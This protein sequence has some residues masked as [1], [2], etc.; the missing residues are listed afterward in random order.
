[1]DEY[2]KKIFDFMKSEEPSQRLQ[3]SI[4]K[5]LKNESLIN[6]TQIM[7]RERIFWMAATVAGI[8][9]GL[10]LNARFQ[11]NTTQPQA[12]MK[13]LQ[14]IMLLHEDEKFD[15]GT[16]QIS[17]LI[18]EY[19]N[20]ATEVSKSGN[21][22][23]AEK[24][25]DEVIPFGQ[26]ASAPQKVSGYFVIATSSVEEAEK[27]VKTHPHLKYKGSIELRPIEKTR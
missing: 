2:D 18:T 22:V 12:A 8:L 10:F 9:L 3:D 5:A 19:T 14:F 13:P 11:F 20:W 24:L 21:L 15:P 1:M 27:L 4:V 23:S 17:E 26:L 7:K 16:A 25:S 6:N